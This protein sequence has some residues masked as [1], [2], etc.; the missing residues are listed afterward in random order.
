MNPY[1]TS[2]A[3]TVA[4]EHNNIRHDLPDVIRDTMIVIA[5]QARDSISTIQTQA[6][7]HRAAQS[8]STQ[9]KSNLRYAPVY[10]LHRL[11]R[12]QQA[13]P[14][15]Y[16]PPVNAV[17]S[18][19]KLLSIGPANPQYQVATNGHRGPENL[20]NDPPSAR[21]PIQTLP[22]KTNT[23]LDHM[24]RSPGLLIT[25]KHSKQ[26]TVAKSTLSKSKRA[27]QRTKREEG[28]YAGVHAA[29][30]ERLAAKLAA[31]I[32]ADKDGDQAMEG[33]DHTEQQVEGGERLSISGY[34]SLDSGVVE[35]CA[36]RPVLDNA[37]KDIT[38]GEDNLNNMKKPYE[39]MA[40][41]SLNEETEDGNAEIKGPNGLVASTSLAYDGD[42]DVKMDELYQPINLVDGGN[43]KMDE[44][45]QL[46]V[47]LSIDPTEEPRESMSQPSKNPWYDR[48]M[49]WRLRVA[50]AEADED[51][52]RGSPSSETELKLLAPEGLPLDDFDEWEDNPLFRSEYND[53]FAQATYVPTRYLGDVRT[54]Y[55]Y[56]TLFQ[57]DFGYGMPWSMGEVGVC[58]PEDKC[59]NG[60]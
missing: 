43:I 23:H 56:P 1:A 19:I 21:G 16:M 22:T 48:I 29:R 18:P 15:R 9:T 14:Y 2:T 26:P 11:M 60:E 52:E 32:S 45:C 7:P 17:A 47:R 38:G 54:P 41:T 55:D 37:H 6:T 35:W 53:P 59:M 13:H 4:S 25:T 10:P 12:R 49:T 31:K 30:L 34:W 42:G 27:S 50:E 36:L 44:L 8:V 58:T 20:S 57:E 39:P 3:T 51:D 5:A 33:E 46:M 28:V 24:P 40:H